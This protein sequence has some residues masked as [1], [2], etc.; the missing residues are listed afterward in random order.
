MKKLYLIA[1]VCLLAA[2]CSS[3]PVKPEEA[4][5]PA[6]KAAAP[7]PAP[8][9]A[10]VQATET[11]AQKLARMLQQISG[12][13]VYFDYDKFEIKPEFQ[14]TIQQHADYMKAAADSKV[15]LEGNADERGSSEYNLA[16]GQKRA[17]AV[18]KA[19]VL[20]GVADSRIEA[21]SYGKEKPRA[22]CHEE[23]CWQENRRV[24]FV[25]K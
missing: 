10:P 5:A 1:A 17:E 3:K 23:R 13:S 25:H 16:L 4:P 21:I 11:E 2:G 20:L 8:T 24:D 12:K 19:M 7:T 14:N 22:T 15:V 6:P 9:P 18:R